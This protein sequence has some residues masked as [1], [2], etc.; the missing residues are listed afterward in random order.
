M[1]KLPDKFPTLK[2]DVYDI[3]DSYECNCLLSKD[4]STPFH[5]VFRAA[6]IADDELKAEGIED[7]DDEFNG[8]RLD[9][10]CNEINRREQAC[11][12]SY[13]FQLE[14]RGR[15]L[16]L[17][18]PKDD[19][20]TTVYFYLLFA[21]RFYM[22]GKKGKSGNVQGGIDGALL[23]EELSAKVAKC[24]W[25]E[26]AK[27]LVFGTA[28]AGSFPDKITDLCLSIGEGKRF[29][30]KNTSKPTEKDAKLGNVQ[31]SVSS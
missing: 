4:G 29:N 14:E 3:A 26:R 8:D 10:V 23:F 30:S 28:K 7:E 19:W 25:G 17:R 18:L 5:K 21:T 20:A 16:K 2:D 1:F 27:T 12:G 6:S 15:K 9:E 13:P 22:A 24:Y 31:K 11:N